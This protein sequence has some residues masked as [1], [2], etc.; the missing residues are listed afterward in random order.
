MSCTPGKEEDINLIKDL[1]PVRFLISPRGKLCMQDSFTTCKDRLDDIISQQKIN[2]FKWQIAQKKGFAI[3]ISIEAIKT[4][5]LVSKGSARQLKENEETLYHRDLK[6]LIEKLNIIVSVFENITKIAGESLRL[7]IALSKLPDNTD[8]VF[9]QS[10]PLSQYIN[11]LDQLYSSYNKENNIKQRV[12]CELPH[13]MNRS[14][15]IRCTT[16]WEYPQYV[17]EWTYL[18]FAFLEEEKKN[19]T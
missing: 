5:A 12:A 2:Y 8:K 14:D 19:R 7:L 13:C 16:A 11:F 17:D 15:L 3:C 1:T 4:R 6:P 10:W 9:H 18:M